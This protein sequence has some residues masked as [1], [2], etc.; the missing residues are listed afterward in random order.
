MITATSTS[1]TMTMITGIRPGIVLS[2]GWCI[3]CAP[4]HMSHRVR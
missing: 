3:C 1:M 2:T 4:I